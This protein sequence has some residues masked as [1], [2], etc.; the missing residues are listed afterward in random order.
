VQVGEPEVLEPVVLVLE[1]DGPLE[2]E[3]A[4]PPL[5]ELDGP[6]GPPLDVVVVAAPELDGPVV[7]APEPEGPVVVAPVVASVADPPCPCAPPAPPFSA[8]P[9]Q[10]LPPRQSAMIDQRHAA[11]F[12]FRRICARRSDRNRAR[13]GLQK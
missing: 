7:V 5:L 13:G 3:L 1:L 4:G 10:A 8:A 2:V 9:P 12:M 6:L 11:I